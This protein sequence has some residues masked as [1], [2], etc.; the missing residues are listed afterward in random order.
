[1]SP[2]RFIDKTFVR[3]RLSVSIYRWVFIVIDKR[4]DQ[5]RRRCKRTWPVA[6]GICEGIA[7]CRKPVLCQ[8]PEGAFLLAAGVPPPRLP[9]RNARLAARFTTS[10]CGNWSF[11]NDVDCPHLS[12][13]QRRSSVLLC[14]TMSTNGV[15]FVDNYDWFYWFG[16][17]W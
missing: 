7:R 3:K 16:T 5:E 6:A 11:Y 1:M 10:C 17:T 9:R 12:P 4:S 2:F 15:F 14:R 8:F 13:A